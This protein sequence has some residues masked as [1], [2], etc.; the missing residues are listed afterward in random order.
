MQDLSKSKI[1]FLTDMFEKKVLRVDKS[2][3]KYKDI[4][5]TLDNQELV[6]KYIHE[7]FTINAGEYHQKYSNTS[8]FKAMLE[9][10]FTKIDINSKVESE[11]N[12]L[13]IGSGSGNST[14]PLLNMFNNSKIIASDLSLELLYILKKTAADMGKGK[15][16]FLLQLNAEELFFKKG[17]FDLVVGVAILHHLFSPEKT[18]ESCSKILKDNGYAIFLNHLK[19]VI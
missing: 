18:L 11:F 3:K 19:V 2:S 14:I 1:N 5:S 8:S 16:L 17:V 13:D 9:N 15:N 6:E 10:A 4:F 12:I 7:Q